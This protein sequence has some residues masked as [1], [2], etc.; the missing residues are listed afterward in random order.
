[1]DE[2]GGGEQSGQQR[3]TLRRGGDSPPS[4]SYY[5]VSYCQDRLI[6]YFLVEL[7]LQNCRKYPS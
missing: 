2:V 1:V 4:S 6:N 3:S 7:S 5:T